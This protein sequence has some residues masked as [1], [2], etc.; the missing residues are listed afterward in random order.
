MVTLFKAS[1][2]YLRQTVEKKGG[3]LKN[4]ALLL[5]LLCYLWLVIKSGSNTV[6]NLYGVL[7]YLQLQSISQNHQMMQAKLSFLINVPVL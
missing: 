7:R 3:Y 6:F 2:I 1:A 5:K 4:P